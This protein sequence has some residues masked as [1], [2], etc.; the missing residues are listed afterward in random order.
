M[1]LRRRAA[2][3]EKAAV[4]K[5]AAEK[6]ATEKAATEKVAA[7]KTGGQK[8]AGRK[9]AAEKAGVQ[10]PVARKAAGENVAAEKVAGENVAAEKTAVAQA[11]ACQV[12]SD[13][14]AADS[15]S[16][17]KEKIVLDRH[18]LPQPSG[19]RKEYTDERGQVT[20]V[21]EWFGYKLHLLVDVLHEVALAYRISSTKAGDNEVLPELVDQAQANLPSGRMNTLAY[22][23]AADDIKVHE[24]LADGGHP[25]AHSEPLAVEARDGTNVAWSRRELQHRV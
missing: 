17:P 25:A 11:A 20:R 18:G 24:K 19:G 3:A 8:T 22:D 5:T 10:K 2:A 7:E 13:S 14:S 12:A 6:A 4:E 9:A 21:V 23:K 16:Q 15:S 1:R